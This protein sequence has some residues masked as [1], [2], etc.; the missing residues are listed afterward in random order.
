MYKVS[1]GMPPP[2]TSELFARRNEHPYNLRHKTEFLQP[3]VNS[4][5]CVTE[6]FSYLGPWFQI[7]VKI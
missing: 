2:Q 5:R 3:F 4:A 7:L 1:K 6:S